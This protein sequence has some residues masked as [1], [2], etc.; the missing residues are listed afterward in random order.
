MI[1]RTTTLPET[2]NS[3]DADQKS[4]YRVIESEK[5]GEFLSSSSEWN[6]GSDRKLFVE[7]LSGSEIK[8]SKL[9]NIT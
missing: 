7:C 2:T 6:Y 5:R 8:V 9:I 1:I 4:I 3:D